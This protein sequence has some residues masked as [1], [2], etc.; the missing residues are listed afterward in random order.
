MPYCLDACPREIFN[1]TIYRIR[2]L[3][4]IVKDRIIMA[5]MCTS[6]KV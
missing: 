1:S 6:A 4:A 2:N 3:D 5:A